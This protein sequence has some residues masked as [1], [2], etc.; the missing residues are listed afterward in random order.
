MVAPH[1]LVRHVHPFLALAARGQDGPVGVDPRRRAG[2]RLRL[3]S[4]DGGSHVIDDVHQPPDRSLVEPPTVVAGRC[5]IWNRARI[6]SVEEGCIVAAHFDVVEHP[7]TAQQVVGDVQNVIGV[8]VRLR[9]LDHAQLLVDLLR[10]PRR[11]HEMMN[12]PNAAARNRLR[13]LGDLIARPLPRE[14]RS[15]LYSRDRAS[16]Q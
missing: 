10:Q 16:D 11:P 12:R 14:L 15:S 13:A 5:R 1:T 8:V 9:L 7:S 3:P 2:E 4:P 6:Q